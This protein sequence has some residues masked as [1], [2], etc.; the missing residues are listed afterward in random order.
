M[1]SSVA[2]E[3][4]F[5]PIIYPYNQANA[6]YI[7]GSKDIEYAREMK[8]NQVCIGAMTDYSFL[9]DFDF[10]EHL[11]LESNI[12]M[13]DIVLQ[14]PSPIA[15]LLP[16]LYHLKGL[17]S[18]SIIDRNGFRNPYFPAIDVSLFPNLQQV[19]GGDADFINLD[20]AISLRSLILSGFKPIND[21]IEV[22]SNL[23]NLDTLSLS[24][25]KFRT[26]KGIEFLQGLKC[27]YLTRC[28][29]LS[30]IDAIQALGSTLQAMRIQNC[31][32]IKSFSSLSKLKN[33]KLLELSG[34]NKIPSLDFISDMPSLKTFVFDVFVENGD[35]TP[36]LSMQYSSCLHK[37]SH[38]NL[39]DRQLPRGTFERGNEGIT[40][41]RRLE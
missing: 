25:G 37:F 33:L 15:N 18:L 1:K 27:L 24:F 13:Q 22:L 4:R 7:Y 30:D 36:C 6:I 12:C 26:L 17:L 11:A 38:Y 9:R 8:I 19:M 5:V 14:N 31:S 16:E 21:G 35:I 39:A 2:E 40:E 32:K 34:S 10:V 28:Q 3:F 29:R 23:R 41:W 20:K